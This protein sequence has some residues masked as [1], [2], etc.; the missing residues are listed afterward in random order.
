MRTEIKTFPAGGGVTQAVRLGN[1]DFELERTRVPVEFLQL[2]P[3]NQR[4]SY[5]LRRVGAAGTDQELHDLLWKDD[6][7]KNLFASIFQNGGLIQ[8]PIVR[9]DGTVVEG[10]CRTVSLRELRKKYPND[11]RW[12]QVFVQFL[13]DE[14]TDEQLTM[15]LGELHIAGRIEWGAFEQAEYVWKMNKVFG[16]TY[17]Y[18]AAHLRWSRSKL[19]QKIA[20][21]EETRTYLAESSDLSAVQRFS[22]FEEFM[23]KA[24]LRD[25]RDRDPEFMSRFRSWV[26]DGKFPD[27]KDVR[28]LPAILEN[29]EAS[30]AFEKDGARSAKTVLH[31]WNPSLASN[32][33]ATVERAAEELRSMPLME[34]EDLKSGHDSKL[35]I[36]KRLNEALRTVARHAHIDLK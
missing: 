17:D 30:Q 5:L 26:K 16:K 35:S 18:L 6:Q 12:E 21:Y 7:V 11:P 13:P 31:E 23:R 3:S 33:W 25:R 14:V 1:R 15:L 2:D 34:I 29:P 10:N 32:L 4:L 20:A 19:A 36:L 8:D 22:H 24:E 27:A 28:D 9:R